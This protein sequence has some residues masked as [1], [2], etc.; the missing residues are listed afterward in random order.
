MTA[1]E[2]RCPAVPLRLL[3][4]LGSPV[5]VDGANLIEVACRGCK[6]DYRKAGEQVSLVVHR[7]NVMGALVETV[8]SP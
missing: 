3:L 4:R 6:T 5:L 7:Y 1:V 8:I 2:I